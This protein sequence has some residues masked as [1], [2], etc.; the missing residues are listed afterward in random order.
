MNEGKSEMMAHGK[1]FLNQ[2]G[3]MQARISRI[4]SWKLHCIICR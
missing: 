2:D 1:E 3:I 4:T